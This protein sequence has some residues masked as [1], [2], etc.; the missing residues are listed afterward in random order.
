MGRYKRYQRGHIREDASPEDTEKKKKLEIIQ[1]GT[2]IASE[3]LDALM[4]KSKELYIKDAV[5]KA[6]YHYIKCDK[7]I[8]V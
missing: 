2:V 5:A 4:A 7:E 6:I 3:I 1:V 8:E